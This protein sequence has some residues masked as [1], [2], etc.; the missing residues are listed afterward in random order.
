MANGKEGEGEFERKE[1]IEAA[2][3]RWHPE[4]EPLRS[5]RSAAAY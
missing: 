2:M 3:H 4:I 1:R 5:N